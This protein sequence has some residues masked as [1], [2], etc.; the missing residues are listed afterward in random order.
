MIG[1]MFLGVAIL[2]LV[3]T[4][5]LAIKIP[6][7][8]GL[9]NFTSWLLRLVLVPLLLVGPFVDEIVGTRQFE[10]LCNEQA[11]L[12][13]AA[14]ADQV[15]RAKVRHSDLRELSGY[16]INISTGRSDYI[17]IDT[18]MVFMSFDDFRTQGGRVAGIALLGGSHWCGAQRS[19]QFK[20]LANR[21]NI[22]KLLDEGHKS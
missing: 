16:W 19:I 4:V 3:L 12:H 14:N 17:D 18:G 9:K 2:W 22:Q 13:V 6:G 7:W 15:K 20:V 11:V 21:L 8:L 10:R 5:Y 1:L